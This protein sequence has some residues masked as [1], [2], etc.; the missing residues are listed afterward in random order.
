MLLSGTFLDKERLAENLL[1]KDDEVNYIDARIPMHD[2]CLI[3]HHNPQ[4]GKLIR[5][6]TGISSSAFGDWQALE[7]YSRIAELR[8]PTKIL[9]YAVNTRRGN[10]IYSAVDNSQHRNERFYVQ[11]ECNERIQI[12][13]WCSAERN[14]VRKSDWLFFD[15]I[16]SSTSRAVDRE[17]FDVLTVHR[18]GYPDWYDMLPLISAIREYINPEADLERV[19]E[20][21][22]Q[23]AVFQTL[24]RNQRNEH[25]HVSIYLSGD[26]HYTD[27]PDY[28]RNR[29]IETNALMRKLKEMYPDDFRSNRQVQIEMI[30][31]VVVAFLKEKLNDIDAFLTAEVTAP[32]NPPEILKAVFGDFEFQGE[33]GKG[34]STRKVEVDLSN[35]PDDEKYLIESFVDEHRNNTDHAEAYKWAIERLEHVKQC[36]ADKGYVDRVKDCKGRR[37]DWKKWIEHCTE[38]KYLHPQNT[39]VN[40]QQK[41]I[42]VMD[43]KAQNAD[44]D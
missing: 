6:I 41:T 31:R 35:L 4:M 2:S 7:L 25:R 34:E 33:Y 27:Y 8:H 26:M 38:K 39:T 42:F 20:Y 12:P 14:M 43:E 29:V 13:D 9:H 19:I 24:L 40:N 5:G 18:N 17:Q 44:V 10:I 23:R 3:I 36:I 16:R 30:A 22:R 28:L 32:D 1:I 21:N 37:P 11:N 15:K